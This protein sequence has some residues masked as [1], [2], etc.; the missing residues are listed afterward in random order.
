MVALKSSNVSINEFLIDNINPLQKIYVEYAPHGSLAN[1]IKSRP[2]QNNKYEATRSAYSQRAG[3]MHRKGYVHC[4]TKPK[5]ILVMSSSEVKITDFGSVKLSNQKGG[6]LG[7]YSIRGTRQFIAPECL[8]CQ[9]YESKFD[10]LCRG[11]VVLEMITGKAVTDPDEDV[12]V[13]EL[14]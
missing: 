11:C 10:L 7:R 2:L 6:V 14:S 4:D 1:L 3:C 5:N 9:E 13:P 12:E 8:A